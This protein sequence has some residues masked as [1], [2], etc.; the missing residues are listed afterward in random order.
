MIETR[1][2]TLALT[3]GSALPLTVAE[4]D[5]VVRGGLV[6]LHE[7]R[8]VTDR[9]R[10]LMRSLAED[11]WLT[12]AP[13]LYHRDGVEGF[14]DA[15]DGDRVREHVA[16]LTEESVLADSDAAFLWLSGRDVPADRQGAIG[17]DAGGAVTLVVAA[18]RSLGAAVTVGGGGIVTPLSPGLPPLAEI[19]GELSCPWLGLYGDQDPATPAGEV[20]KLQ[21][22][23]AAAR[24]ATDVVRFTGGQ[25]GAVAD[26]IDLSQRTRNWLDTHL[27]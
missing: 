18:N 7:A 5:H 2:E 1:T 25:R 24:V 19:A 26:A 23:A 9:V 27:R 6:V 11:G 10:S 13:H 17:F 12:A 8:G 14:A 3:D 4:P 15:H 22:A 16:R 20:T 21:E